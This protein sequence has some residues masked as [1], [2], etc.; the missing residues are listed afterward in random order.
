M[1]SMKEHADDDLYW[2]KEGTGIFKDKGKTHTE[3]SVRREG[4]G[5]WDEGRRKT[6][7]K[8]EHRQRW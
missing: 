5:Q 2:C 1:S 6:E 7:G 3:C 8:R 4:S